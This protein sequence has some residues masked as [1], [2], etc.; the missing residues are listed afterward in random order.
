M[1]FS[2]QGKSWIERASSKAIYFIY[3]FVGLPLVLGIAYL[4]LPQEQAGASSVLRIEQAQRWIEPLPADA[5]FTQEYFAKLSQ[6]PG[7]FAQ[8]EWQTAT[9]PSVVELDAKENLGEKP[10]LARAWFKF[11]VKPSEPASPSNPF[12]LYGTRAMGGPYSVW[13]NGQLVFANLDDWRMLWNKPIFIPIPQN[14]YQAGQPVEIMLALPH[15]ATLGYALGSLYLGNQS[16]LMLARDTRFVLQTGLPLVSMLMIGVTGLFSLGLWARRRHDS[17]NLWLFVMAVSLIVCNLQFTHDVA[18]S[19]IRSQWFGSLVDSAISWVFL[20]FFIFVQRYVGASYPKITALLAFFTAL[21]TLLTLP[22]WGWQVHAILLQHYILLATYGLVMILL[23]WLAVSQKSKEAIIFCI[24]IWIMLLGGLHDLSR[25]TSQLKPDAIFIFPY[26]AFVLFFVA[27]YLLRRRHLSLLSQVEQNNANLKQ[28]LNE[29]QEQLLNQQN[30][31]IQA[32]EQA[33]LLAERTRLLRDIHDGIGSTLT[34]TVIHL[35]GKNASPEN[36]AAQVQSCLE[37]IRMVMDSIEPESHDL[38][39]LF[40]SLRRRFTDAFVAAGI[41]AHWQL[42]DIEQLQLKSSGDALHL[43]RIIQEI[44]TNC[45]K[46]SQ[47]KNF[48]VTTCLTQN[49]ESQPQLKIE[50]TD[51][52]Q[53]FIA[54]SI[55]A[56]SATGRGILNVQQRVQ[57]M[58]GVFEIQSKQ[59]H[60]VRH[61]IKLPVA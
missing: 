16:D 58:H 50:F 21:N 43:T 46:H 15:R 8:A 25:M 40:A 12:V 37:D 18:Y 10:V 34:A 4:L 27:E 38:P 42:D 22:I 48:S 6:Q 32:R 51:D 59:S 19:A 5:E 13:V 39:T 41:Q 35:R 20:S 56:A 36:A 7:N 17:A 3:L 49:V 24:S 28:K 57:K 1:N 23:T 30:L 11:S 31:L 52:G 26:G 2:A 60:G 55:V 44:I 14:T 54:A 29:Q 53:G 33:V 61:G 9:L 45:L 47:A